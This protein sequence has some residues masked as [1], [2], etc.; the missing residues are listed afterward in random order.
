[1]AH[2]SKVL[3]FSKEDFDDWN[4]RMQAH[5]AA[6]DDDRW[7]VITNGPLKI[8]K[9]NTTIAV[10]EDAQEMVE[11]QR[12]EWTSE[13]KKKANLDNVAKDI[14]YKTL[15]KNTFSKI[16]MCPTTKEIWEKLIQISEKNEQTKEKK[17]SVAMQKFENLKMKDGETLRE[18]DERFSILVNELAALGKEL[19]NREVA[20]KLMRALPRE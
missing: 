2:F 17:L 5:L 6:Q 14:L 10:T 15:D 18:F 8:L 9:P 3:M 19:D 13:D 12:S 20:L 1:M 4:I 16:K 11:K 7:F